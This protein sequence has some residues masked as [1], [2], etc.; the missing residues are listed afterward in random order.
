MAGPHVAQGRKY[1][2]LDLLAALSNMI[3]SSCSLAIRRFCGSQS[4]V[5]MHSAAIL[6]V[7]ASGFGRQRPTWL[8]TGLFCKRSI[9]AQNVLRELWG[10]EFLARPERWASRCSACRRASPSSD[11]TAALIFI[12][13]PK[14]KKG[15]S[16]CLRLQR[17]Q[18]PLRQ[19]R[20]IDDCPAR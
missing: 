15:I 16:R 10:M 3:Q 20:G 2:Y 5:V 18:L 7:D 6:P 12:Q 19:Y 8:V 13:T 4:C 17:S 1:L 11:R 14:M 9:A